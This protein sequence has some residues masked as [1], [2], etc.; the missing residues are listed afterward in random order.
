MPAF[1]PRFFLSSSNMATAC[2]QRSLTPS[3]SPWVYACATGSCATPVVTEGHVIPL[4][5]SLVCSLRRPSPKG[6]D[7]TGSD[8]SH[9][10]GSD[11]SH[12]NWKY[13]MRMRNWKCSIS[14]LVGSFWP[15]VTM[16][17]DRKRTWPEVCSAHAPLFA[18]F[19]FLV[20]GGWFEKPK[21]GS[22]ACKG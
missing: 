14:A 13:V 9:V 6:S 18:A 11:V 2:D 21:I 8:V 22:L 12:R 7:V 3:G 10:T 1:F 19:F 17:R 4:E 16:S 15:E 20:V 5:V